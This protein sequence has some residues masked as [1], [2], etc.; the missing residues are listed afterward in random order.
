MNAFHRQ[1][2]YDTLH[3][4]EALETFLDFCADV[5]CRYDGN[6]RVME[7][8]N[9][10]TQDLLHFMELADNMGI[11]EGFKAYKRMREVRRIRRDA[12]NEN[13][14]LQPIYDLLCACDIE[15]RLQHVLGI[16]RA[17]RENINGR[18]YSPRTDILTREDI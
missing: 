15:H 13:D 16:L 8:T 12:K 5:R 6:I 1:S 10:E 11:A 7:E 17:K 9:M 3:P 14:L 4:V 18:K 2:D